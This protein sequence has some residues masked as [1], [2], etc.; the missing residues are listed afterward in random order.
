MAKKEECFD[1][2]AHIMKKALDEHQRLS[3]LDFFELR[4]CWLEKL[5]KAA[6]EHF[7]CSPED[8]EFI[9][10]ENILKE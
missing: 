8:I 1:I 6:A 9:D 5:R 3:P 4:R 2:E 7:G 10:P